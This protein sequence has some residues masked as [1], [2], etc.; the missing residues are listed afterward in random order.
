MEKILLPRIWDLPSI[1]R[2]S[3]PLKSR[4]PQPL[5][6]PSRPW[7]TLEF[8]KEKKR[9]VNLNVLL[10]YA[11]LDKIGSKVF[12]IVYSCGSQSPRP[13][14][15]YLGVV[16]SQEFLCCNKQHDQKQLGEEGVY[17]TYI[18]IL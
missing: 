16:L 1:A 13:A 9:P 5:S 4:K 7:F 14:A 12:N 17:L 15:A 10:G 8:K 3:G 6:H 2:N 18:F 11:L